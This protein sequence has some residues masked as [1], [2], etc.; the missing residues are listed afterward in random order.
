[1]KKNIVFIIII[2]IL[3]LG[4]VGTMVS[5][6]FMYNKNNDLKD[7]ISAKT[8]EIEQLNTQ[9]NQ[10]NETINTEEEFK[11]KLFD[12]T[13]LGNENF[14]IQT[15]AVGDSDLIARVDGK[16]NALVS[17]ISNSFY[18]TPTASHGK[19]YIIEGTSGKV[20]NTKVMTMGNG[21]LSTIFMIMEDGTVEYMDN[22]KISEGK[23]ISAGK[24]EGLEK[25]VDLVQVSVR[26]TVAGGHIAVVAI[27]VDGNITL[28]QGL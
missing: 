15:Q 2:L 14:I 10:L 27:D 13:E 17:L 16:G 18:K 12:V 26:S 11:H 22:S 3:I 21:G 23:F 28:V 8:Q 6:I 7:E 4:L 9:I 25:I 5:T 20:Y 24:I 19:E 1:M